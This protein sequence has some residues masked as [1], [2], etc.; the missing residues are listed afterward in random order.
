MMLCRA[1]D[2]MRPS[3]IVLESLSRSRVVTVGTWLV[4]RQPESID[5][6]VSQG[7]SGLTKSRDARFDGAMPRRGASNM[8]TSKNRFTHRDGWWGELNLR[9]QHVPIQSGYEFETE[10]AALA[11]LAT[12]PPV[13]FVGATEGSTITADQLNE[14]VGDATE[15]A[16]QEAK[17][18]RES[19]A[20][21]RRLLGWAKIE[22]ALADPNADRV[23]TEGRWAGFSRGDAVAWCWNLFQYEP[24]GFT[25]PGSQVRHEAMQQLQAG[26]LPEVFGYPE[27]ARELVARGLTPREYRRHQEALGARTFAA[28]DVKHPRP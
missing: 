18:Q 2:I 23:I 10:Q 20:E 4:A 9:Y 13:G 14:L 28:L 8:P 27:R 17:N 19:A 26:G 1:T 22:E 7:K 15:N 6:R 25:H 24:H 16:E 3:Y 12:H 11:V 21:E 5:S